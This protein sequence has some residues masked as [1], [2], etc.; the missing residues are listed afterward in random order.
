MPYEIITIPFNTATKSFHSDELNK[1]C[2]NKRVLNNKIEFFSDGKNSFWSVFIEYEVVLEHFA[3]EPKG[4][5]EAG[6]LCYERLRE[7]R[8]TTAEKEGVPP[9]VIA[10]NS[11]L[12]EIINRE[13]KTLES[14]KQINGFGRKKVEKY[15]K[16]ITEIIKTFYEFPINEE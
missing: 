6:K 4:L 2:L 15:G 10:R 13:T 8:K 14:L 3:N 9:F 11:Q 7:W 1:F 12:A 16:D 5:T